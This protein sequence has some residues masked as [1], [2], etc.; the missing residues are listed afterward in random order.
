M[1]DWETYLQRRKD[2]GQDPGTA[3][4]KLVVVPHYYISERLQ[5]SCGELL[6]IEQISVAQ[7]M[8]SPWSMPPP[9]R[10]RKRRK[11]TLVEGYMYAKYT[12][13]WYKLYP[14]I[15]Y[16]RNYMNYTFLEITYQ[17]IYST[18]LL[19]VF[20][21]QRGFQKVPLRDLVSKDQ[22]TI[23]ALSEVSPTSKSRLTCQSWNPA[24]WQGGHTLFLNWWVVGCHNP[25]EHYQWFQRKYQITSLSTKILLP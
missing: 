12:Q 20:R 25:K 21:V 9:Q 1:W 3:G 8:N 5:W 4:K 6:Q 13:S 23:S 2:A 11:W 22:T 16:N 7:H 24:Q 19:L 17:F 14:H 10:K 18:L 15:L